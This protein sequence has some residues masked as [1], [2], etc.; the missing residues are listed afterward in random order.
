MTGSRGETWAIVQAR[1]TSTRLPGKVLRPLAGEPMVLRQLERIGRATNLD[2]IIVAT[3]EDPSDDELAI[4]LADAGYDYVRGP[5]DDVLA[6]FIMALDEYQP[7]V[8]VRLTADCPLISPTV[9]DLVVERFHSGTADYVSNTMQPT[10]P[11]GLDVEVTTASALREV[12][13]VS[14]DAHE[15]EHV[16]LG[17]YRRTDRFII[18]NVADPAGR[19]NSHLRWTVDNP[20]DLDF[21]TEVYRELLP[22]EFDYEDVLTLLAK[23]P[24]LTRTSADAPRNAA[25]DGVDTGAMHH[26]KPGDQQ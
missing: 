10:Y 18:E 14:T 6:R 8:V 5:L 17:I 13:E 22:V 7:D 19:D 12:A 2:G 4:T 24:E 11:D 25:L 16:T 15:R 20:D 1:S 9:I 26:S 3:S 23:R 21:V